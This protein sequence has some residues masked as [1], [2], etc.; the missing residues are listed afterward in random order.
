MSNKKRCL[1]NKLNGKKL[2]VLGGTYASIDIVRIAK[3]EGV[4]TVVADYLETGVA[5]ELADEAALISTT[6]MDSL[7]AMIRGRGIDGVLCGA[8]EFQLL[9]VMRLCEKAGLPFYCTM[10][11]WNICQDKARFKG[12]CRQNGIPVIP[13][14]H[15][16]GE[17]LK[18]DLEKIQYPVV[19]KPVDASASRGLSLC[20]N[21]DELKAAYRYALDFSRKKQVIVEKSIES[22]KSVSARYLAFEGNILLFSV[23]TRYSVASGGKT[24]PFGHVFIFPSDETEKYVREVN[25]N[26]IAMFKGIGMKNGSF[27]IQG[28]IDEANGDYFFM[29]ASLRLNAINTYRIT[30]P[31]TG[32]NDVKMMVRYALG[33]PFSTADEIGRID[34]ALGG[35]IGC[36][37]A[38]PL[39]AGKIGYVKGIGDIEEAYPCVGFSKYYSE[40]DTIS[41]DKLGTL[42][43]IYGRF[44]FIAESREEASGIIDFI[45]S[46]LHIADEN[47]QD[48]VYSRFD[49]NRIQNMNCR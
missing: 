17:F 39:R 7:H 24:M 45:N 2:L 9:N 19:V 20:R 49:P 31:T 11:Q 5:K 23:N 14:Y 15:I 13:E 28:M 3:A 43:S 38:V 8:S 25:E 27:C 12:M 21:H 33:Q 22:K 26:V 10:D 30:E 18:H 48:M 29:E 4:Y 44:D 32:I 42:D 40:G 1:A 37:L 16:T 41:I 46:S 6:D 35:K 36:I 47:G 34:L